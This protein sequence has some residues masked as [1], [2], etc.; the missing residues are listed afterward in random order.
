MVSILASPNSRHSWS[1][2]LKVLDIASKT[3]HA[4]NTSY[5]TYSNV[6]L[7]W[8]MLLLRLTGCHATPYLCFQPLGIVKT[9]M[10]REQ[11]EKGKGKNPWSDFA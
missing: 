9:D 5:S 10:E 4:H 8:L 3:C 2:A 11:S 7:H 1:R 6:F